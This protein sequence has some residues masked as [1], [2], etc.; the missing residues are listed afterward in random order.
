MAATRS[1]SIRALRQLAASS[2][3][4]SLHMTGPAEFP[5]PLLTTERPTASRV[6]RD[7]EA[8]QKQADLAEITTLQPAR[9]FNTSRSLKA[10]GDSSTIDFAF[11]PDFDPD[12]ATLPTVRVPLLPTSNYES[13]SS[14]VAEVEEPVSHAPSVII[15]L[16]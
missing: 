14:Y 12:T 8:A 6:K 11:L 15:F 3:R 2:Q 13:A 7:I 10:V 16:R 9:H 5:S 1:N 4:R